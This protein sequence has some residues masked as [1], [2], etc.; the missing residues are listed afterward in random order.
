MTWETAPDWLQLSLLAI[1]VGITWYY[2]QATWKT[3]REIRDENR[4]AQTP[5]LR[6]FVMQLGSRDEIRERNHE[7]YVG[8]RLLLRNAGPGPATDIRLNP[9]SNCECGFV[10]EGRNGVPADK[11]P[12][13]QGRQI[14]ALLEGEQVYL[15]FKGT[16]KAML[17]TPPFVSAIA[18]DGLGRRYEVKASFYYKANLHHW[19]T[20]HEEE[21]G[22]VPD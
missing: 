14:S 6:F 15:Q 3:Y 10:G 13:G 22:E 20:T 7:P 16:P 9:K 19:T 12:R 5:C 18:A 21:I 11:R 8:G 1:L 4:R 2:A 17:D